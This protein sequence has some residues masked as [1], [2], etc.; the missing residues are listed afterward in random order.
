MPW[1]PITGTR[2]ARVRSRSTEST[3][4]AGYW[5]TSSEDRPPWCA[6]ASAA[7]TREHTRSITVGLVEPAA[8]HLRGRSGED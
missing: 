1:S 7:G 3:P 4:N 6:G 2:Y 8:E 5:C